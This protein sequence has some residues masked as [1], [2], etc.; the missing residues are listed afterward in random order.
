MRIE[1]GAGDF[2]MDV[3]SVEPRGDKL[4][5]KAMMGVW[6][7]EVEL[8]PREIV[9]LFTLHLR[10]AVIW[11]VLRLPWLAWRSARSG[12]QSTKDG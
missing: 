5:F 3:Q 1:S 10:P 11:Y 2:D 12:A 6:V 7:A 9:H 8:T 4:V